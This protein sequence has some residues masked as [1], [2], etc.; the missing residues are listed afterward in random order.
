[1]PVS[2]WTPD[3]ANSTQTWNVQ[4]SASQ[5]FLQQA[6]YTVALPSANLSYWVV[7]ERLQARAAVAETM[8]RPDLNQLAPNATNN[9]IN[10]TP[11]LDYSGTA[12][13]KPVKAWSADLSIEWYYKPH[14]AL[15]AAR[16]AGVVTGQG[17]SSKV[18][19]TSLPFVPDGKWVSQTFLAY[20]GMGR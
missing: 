8:S 15:N 14:S 18:S 10:G 13:L 19:T 2:L 7:P 11:E 9:A 5:Q 16:T 6:T 20:P 1:M 17:P 3:A 12:G 4:Y